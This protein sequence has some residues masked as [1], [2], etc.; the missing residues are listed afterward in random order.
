MLNKVT[1]IQS[2]T[3]G[4]PAFFSLFLF[5]ILSEG[6]QNSHSFD[7]GRKVNEIYGDPG[8]E[9]NDRS[10]N[11]KVQSYLE[12]NPECT[13]MYFL[14]GDLLI[15]QDSLRKA[16]EIFERSLTLKNAYVYAYYKLGNINYLENRNDR[17]IE[18]YELALSGKQKVGNYYFES[19]MDESERRFNIPVTELIFQIGVASYSNRELEKASL[20][21]KYCLM[22]KYNLKEANY[23]LGNILI[24]QNRYSESC[25]YFR[26][27]IIYGEKGAADYLRKY[28]S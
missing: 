9:K 26:K 21:F 3:L 17:A 13:G 15:G 25:D 19:Y 23:Y 6:C 16:E 1:D 2:K 10:L 11:A 12:S 28:C 27:A 5:F 24:E 18:Y 7:C 8:I 14:Y 22:Q 4:L 20:H